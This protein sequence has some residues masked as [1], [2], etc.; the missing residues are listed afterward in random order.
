MREGGIFFIECHVSGGGRVG[1]EGMGEFVLFVFI[2]CQR[3]VLKTAASGDVPVI[4]TTC[5]SDK[6][7][8]SGLTSHLNEHHVLS[9]H[10]GV[11]QDDYS[12]P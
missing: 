4:E 2:K 12:L 1:E 10:L 9:V 5:S 6:K 7:D 11:L 8:S 3:Q